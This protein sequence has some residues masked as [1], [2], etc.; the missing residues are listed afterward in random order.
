ME[1][2]VAVGVVGERVVVGLLPNT[3]GTTSG[4]LLSQ[5]PGYVTPVATPAQRA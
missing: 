2:V 5:G 1:V 4:A 3:G